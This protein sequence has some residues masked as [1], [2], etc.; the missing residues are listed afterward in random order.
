MTG[1]APE[2]RPG[3]SHFKASVVLAVPSAIDPQCIPPSWAARSERQASA[4][5]ANRE[6]HII[7]FVERATSTLTWENVKS[8]WTSIRL[9]SER[10]SSRLFNGGCPNTQQC[11]SLPALAEGSREFR[12]RPPALRTTQIETLPASVIPFRL[13]SDGW[14]RTRSIQ[15]PL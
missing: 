8:V 3:K 5:F 4:A 13:H 15:R 2:T 1:I 10:N 7:C 9:G 6:P 12:V 11:W 14:R